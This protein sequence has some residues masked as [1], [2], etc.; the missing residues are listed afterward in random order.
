MDKLSTNAGF[1]QT[2]SLLFPNSLKP[3]DATLAKMA[4]ID[5][6]HS[7]IPTIVF[8]TLFRQSALKKSGFA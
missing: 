6:T 1:P 2:P 5:Q 7:T 4:N 8:F 3:N